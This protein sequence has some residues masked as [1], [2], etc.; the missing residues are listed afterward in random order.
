V[1]TSCKT[2]YQNLPAF[3]E[4]KQLQAVILTPAGSNSP[5]AY[6]AVKKEFRPAT[7]AGLPAQ[8]RFLPLPGNWGFIPSTKYRNEAQEDKLLDV[9]V[10][11]E[12]VST[13]TIQEVV[14]IS[15][16]LLNVEGQIMPIIIAVPA[17][18]SEQVIAAT[19][20]EAF[21][22]EYPAAKEILQQWFLHYQPEK[23]VRLAGWKNEKF[24]DQFIRQWLQ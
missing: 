13:G 21:S 19:Y 3:S 15:T 14:P 17:R 10:L 20:F 11:S 7:D 4:N 5:Q 24:T 23:K 9:L 12:S 22:E 8:I 18:P 16:L 2:D 1:L 6:D